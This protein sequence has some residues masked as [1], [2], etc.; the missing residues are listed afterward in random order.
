MIKPA[1]IVYLYRYCLCNNGKAHWFVKSSEAAN[2]FPYFKHHR[3][4]TQ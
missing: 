3:Q 2:V 4:Q 1:V